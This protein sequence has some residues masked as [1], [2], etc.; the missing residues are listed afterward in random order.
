MRFPQAGIGRS[1]GPPGRG[2]PGA[3]GAPG[4]NGANGAD[5]PP[6]AGA[7][8]KGVW[9]SG[10]TYALADGVTRN[11]LPYIS[12][13]AGN[14][15]H[16][17]QTDTTNWTL[18]STYLPVFNVKAYGAV[19]DGVVATGAITSGA[20]VLS[21]PTFVSADVGKPVLVTN[22][23]ALTS[24]GT[25]SAL[26]STGGAITAIPVNAL[27]GTV[28]AGPIW[29]FSGTNNQQFITTGA[30]AAATSIPVTSQTPNFAYPSGSTVGLP[31]DLRTTVLS[32][33]GGNATLAANA[34]N[35]VSG[36]PLVYGTD[37]TTAVQA[38]INA[39]LAAAGGVVYFPSS[40][41]V[42]GGAIQTTNSCCS[43]LEIAP[44]PASG[45][46]VVELLGDRQMDRHSEGASA[47]AG[48]SFIVSTS[49]GAAYTANTAIPAVIGT[50]T[51]ESHGGNG[52][53]H[54][55]VTVRQL[56]FV[57]PV[58]PK[59]AAVGLG[60]ADY[61]HVEGV[62]FTTI[63]APGF[64]TQPTNPTGIGLVGPYVGNWGNNVVRDVV[65]EG[66][67]QGLKFGEH[68]AGENVGIYKC[69]IG[70]GWSTHQH[71]S[72]FGYIDIERCTHGIA[73]SD[74]STGGPSSA[75]GACYL[76]IN[77]LDTENGGGVGWFN[78]VTNVSDAGAQLFGRIQ[79]HLW[80]SDVWVASA[81]RLYA[82]CLGTYRDLSTK[83]HLTANQSIT[84]NTQT[85][86]TLAAGTFVNQDQWN[87][88]GAWAAGNPT[89]L[90]VP[91]N[92][93]YQIAA[94][95]TWGAANGGT[96]RRAMLMMDGNV[97]IAAQVGPDSYSCQNI[98]YTGYFVGGDYIEAWVLQD[99]G[100]AMN[101]L[102]AAF[103]TT[104]PPTWV[105]MTRLT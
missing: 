57:L 87:D 68:T 46:P 89:R 43:Q 36:S 27:A 31:S 64:A 95:I 8:W 18:I 96:Q 53:S 9:S 4:A 84:N 56:A 52:Q 42:I 93:V 5:G 75:P 69:F 66:Y 81:L 51:P 34:G 54:I 20:A 104:A 71:P 105:S 10:T 22:A 6:G 67:Y 62:Q 30:A 79:Y 78:K 38:A 40:R 45:L 61:A 49:A 91:S 74:P 21:G 1:L 60:G 25:T 101:V 86:L 24:S 3:P 65:M 48:G 19:G 63:E 77:D 35:S 98:S 59:L 97:P 7:T 14:L 39:C 41:Y 90:T 47:A 26:L 13:A 82:K 2:S 28:A 29:L 58:N 37:D 17:P 11:G 80:S 102:A 92:G 72:N 94:Q 55:R 33:A 76:T 12:N 32:V 85:A 23:G 99:S 16:D 73:Y 100:A 15:N 103:G 44:V 50:P 83:A 88:L 70:A